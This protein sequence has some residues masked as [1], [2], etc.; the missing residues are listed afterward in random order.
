MGRDVEV[1]EEPPE[2]E[3]ELPLDEGEQ[4]VLSDLIN[5]VLDKGVVISGHVTISVADIDLLALD[6]RLLLA[7]VETAV[8]R[9]TGGITSSAP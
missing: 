3:K 6:L 2:R 5:R 1:I 9:G 4:L 7:S 8:A